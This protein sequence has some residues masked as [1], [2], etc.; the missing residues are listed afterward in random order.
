MTLKKNLIVALVTSVIF[1][2]TN[3]HAQDRFLVSSGFKLSNYVGSDVSESDSRIGYS[4]GLEIVEQFATKFSF[5]T[6]VNYETSGSDDLRTNQVSAPFMLGYKFNETFLFGLGGTIS[7]LTS[8]NDSN[9]K[10]IKNGIDIYEKAIF[11]TMAQA[12]YLINESFEAYASF[13]RGLSEPFK[14]SSS[15]V[16]NQSIQLGLYYKIL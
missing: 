5:H 9:G 14:N 1:N 13:K 7:V 15:K 3:L 4:V 10:K 11:D 12:R 16:F 8:L 2:L 6:G